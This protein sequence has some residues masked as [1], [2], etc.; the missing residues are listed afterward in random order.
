MYG[1]R[2]FCVAAFAFAGAGCDSVA[3][4]FFQDGEPAAPAPA[5][6]PP[7]GPAAAP[8][9]PMIPATPIA[10]VAAQP[11]DSDKGDVE[12]EP[13]GAVAAET[14]DKKEVG[15]DEKK[16]SKK[17][18]PKKAP[19]GAAGK[20]VPVQTKAVVKGN[21]SAG[22]VGLKKLGTIKLKKAGDSSEPK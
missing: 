6:L 22:Q 19:E 15:A 20:S 11:A 1:L 2:A 18:K 21:L 13:R 12:A 9:T 7:A 16:I 4:P 14:T 8:A 10:P 5:A 17:K 3:I